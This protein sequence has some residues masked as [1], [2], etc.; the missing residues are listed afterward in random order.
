MTEMH[1]DMAKKGFV[2]ASMEIYDENG[3]LQGFFMTY[4][5]DSKLSC[6]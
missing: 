6:D 1:Q 4:T 3:D 5:K 2:F